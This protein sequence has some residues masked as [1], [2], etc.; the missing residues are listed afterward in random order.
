MRKF[1]PVNNAPE[2][3]IMPER[4]TKL[5]AGYDI[6]TPFEVTIA[7][8]TFAVIPLYVKIILNDNEYLTVV[9]R[10]SLYKKHKLI[11]TG[12]MG[13][14]DADYANNPDNDGNILAILYNNSDLKQTL[15]KDEAIVQG[16]IQN[17]LVTDDDN[18]TGERVGGIGSTDKPKMDE[19]Q[20]YDN[21]YAE[22]LVQPIEVMQEL[23]PQE[24]FMAAL[25]FNI[26]KYNSRAGH[27]AGEAIS[28]DKA[29][30]DRYLAWLYE[31]DYNNTIIDLKKDYEC[32]EW[33]KENILGVL[34]EKRTEMENERRKR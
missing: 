20:Y 25:L 19:T 8:H 33:Y 34:N 12:S 14:I 31:A 21:H 13:V 22:M 11:M 17:Y 32:P 4:K 27:K 3:I 29:K 1:L 26:N 28:K 5:S 2:N 6:C 7:P 23:L 16:I 18:A 24:Q 9:P 15:E 10:S 30:R